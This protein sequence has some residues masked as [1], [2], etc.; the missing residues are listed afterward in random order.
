V[1]L[2]LSPKMADGIVEGSVGC[3]QGNTSIFMPEPRTDLALQSAPAECFHWTSNVHPYS[4]RS[5]RDAQNYIKSK[6]FRSR[7]QYDLSTDGPRKD[8][9]Y[10]SIESISFERMRLDQSQRRVFLPS[11]FALGEVVGDLSLSNRL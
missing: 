1:N 10:C 7:F 8:L 9:R 2:D 3:V 6:L 11:A 5:I 4:G